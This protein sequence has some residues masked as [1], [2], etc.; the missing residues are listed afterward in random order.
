MLC[1]RSGL[2]LELIKLIYIRHLHIILI[3]NHLTRVTILIM[4]SRGI[5]MCS[6]LPGSNMSTRIV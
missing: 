3:D 1:R 4:R 5:H 2:E 6:W